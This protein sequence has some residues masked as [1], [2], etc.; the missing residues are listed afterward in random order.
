MLSLLRAAHHSRSIRPLPH[1]RRFAEE[2]SSR[3]IVDPSSTVPNLPDKPNAG[4]SPPAILEQKES[5]ITLQEMESFVKVDQKHGLWHFFREFYSED[6]KMWQRT[7]VEFK[8]QDG[9]S[10]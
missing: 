5:R 1:I 3:A 4:P 8:D 7:T 9:Y 2:V 6:K 10:G